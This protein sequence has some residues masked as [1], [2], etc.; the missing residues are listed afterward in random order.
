MRKNGNNCAFLS[1]E[2]W[3]KL[4]RGW[5]IVGCAVRT[6]TLFQL[7]ARKTFTVEEQ[8][9]TW[10]HDIPARLI[11]LDLSETEEEQKFGWAGAVGFNLPRCGV[12]RKPLGQGL[13][14]ARN[15]EG[16]VLTIGGRMPPSK[17][18]I[19]QGLNPITEKIKCI[20]GYAYSVGSNRKIYKRV[21]VGRWERMEGLPKPGEGQISDVGFNDMDGHSEKELYAV[22]TGG[23]VWR[24]DGKQWARCDFPSNEQ[25][26]TVTIGGDG[27]VYISGEGGNLWVGEKDTWKQVHEG[28][29]SL[30]NN[31]AVWFDGMLWLC[32]DYQLRVWDGKEVRRPRHNGRDVV[33]TGHMDAYDGLLV[34]AGLYDV[35]AY[36]G[37]SW[38]TLVA[39]YA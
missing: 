10:D 15:V 17:E 34:I 26:G 23:D 25:L 14:V 33:Y 20:D 1:R 7:V 9:G 30:L 22:G 35:H 13:M 39:P 16:S 21:A 36:D 27:K 37:T 32:S 19:G 3:E 29:S 38:T 6:A 4:F 11:T 28:E 8:L 31:N 12:S 5:H 2:S 24:Y 18:A